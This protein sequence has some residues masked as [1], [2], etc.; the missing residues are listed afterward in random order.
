MRKSVFGKRALAGI[1]AGIIAVGAFP[2]TAFSAKKKDD[3]IRLRVCNWEEYIR[4][5]RGGDDRSSER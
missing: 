4:L 5:G 2:V 1:L 3:V